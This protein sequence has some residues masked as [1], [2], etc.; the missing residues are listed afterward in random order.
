MSS[1]EALDYGIID[2]IIEQMDNEKCT[3]EKSL[4][5]Y[6][7]GVKLINEVSKKV[8]KIYIIVHKFLYL[9]YIL[10]LDL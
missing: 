2:K 8:D 9:F 6:E 7:K 3:I 1:S 10:F 4:E 5:L